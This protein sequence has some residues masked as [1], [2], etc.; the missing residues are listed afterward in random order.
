MVRGCPTHMETYFRTENFLLKKS[1]GEMLFKNELWS[2]CFMIFSSSF[3]NK[4]N[5]FY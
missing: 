5:H 1:Y 2:L 3:L 4:S